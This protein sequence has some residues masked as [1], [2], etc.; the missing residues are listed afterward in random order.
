M[1]SLSGDAFHG[2]LPPPSENTEEK[3]GMVA[4]SSAMF[5]KEPRQLVFAQQTVD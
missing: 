2:N 1:I 5:L 4:G 3:T